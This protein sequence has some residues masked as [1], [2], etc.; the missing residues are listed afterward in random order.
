MGFPHDEPSRNVNSEIWNS[1]NYT[2]N[3]ICRGIRDNYTPIN[4]NSMM[5]SLGQEISL[6]QNFVNAKYL[7]R[8]NLPVKSGF[9]SYLMVGSGE[10]Y[11]GNGNPVALTVGNDNYNGDVYIR[12]HGG[13]G[14][15]LYGDNAYSDR[16]RTD[17]RHF[18]LSCNGA[19]SLD[20]TCDP[21]NDIYR[22]YA[23]QT[24]KAPSMQIGGYDEV[25]EGGGLIANSGRFYEGLYAPGIL[26]V[27]EIEPLY[28]LVPGGMVISGLLQIGATESDSTEKL[29]VNGYSTFAGTVYVQDILTVGGGVFTASDSTGLT[30]ID[31]ATIRSYATIGSSDQY[32][33][34]YAL[35]VGKDSMEGNVFIKPTNG[36]GVDI[37]GDSDLY[38]FITSSGDRITIGTKTSYGT[39]DE[40][41]LSFNV[42]ADQYVNGKFGCNGAD[43]SAKKP[44]PTG[45]DSYK[46]GQ[47]IAC[48]Q[49]FGFMET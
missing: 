16:I 20:L 36:V 37:H 4:K 46:I 33:Y 28:D 2:P 22:I 34:G 15:F 10:P 41:M 5:N 47:I 31:K 12:T 14:I 13:G 21:E 19:T 38:D 35:T 25:V 26:K 45:A 44:I 48:L 39:F 18:E 32:N 6:L 1:G 11:A 3:I 29:K 23:S 27:G 24:I 17:G 30:W 9:I 40:N 42:Y 49:A 7:G 8:D 43:P